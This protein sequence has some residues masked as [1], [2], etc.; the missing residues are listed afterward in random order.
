VST[1][2]Y[3]RSYLPGGNACNLIVILFLE[4][5][6]PVLGRRHTTDCSPHVCLRLY[7]PRSDYSPDSDT[8]SLC[9]YRDLEQKSGYYGCRHLCVGDQCCIPHPGQVLSPPSP[10]GRL[11]VEPHA[12]VVW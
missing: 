4:L 9:Q 3:I 5:Y 8:Y 7:P 11:T 1:T 2:S 6:L 10:F 12:N